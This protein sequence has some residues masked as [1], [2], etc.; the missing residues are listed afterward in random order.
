MSCISE[1]TLLPNFLGGLIALKTVTKPK[2]FNISLLPKIPTI[3]ELQF[4]TNNNINLTREF[5]K[6]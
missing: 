5:G 3:I 4:S 6:N 2:S 1:N